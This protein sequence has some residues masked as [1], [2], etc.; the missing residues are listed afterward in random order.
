MVS[1]PSILIANNT[2]VD[3]VSPISRWVNKLHSHC[4]DL[5]GMY[6]HGA[7]GPGLSSSI[8]SIAARP[9]I[10][11][12]TVLGSAHPVWRISRHSRTTSSTTPEVPSSVLTVSMCLIRTTTS[13]PIHSLSTHLRAT[14]TLKT[15]HQQLIM[16]RTVRCK[17]FWP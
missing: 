5:Q 16:A 2:I 10:Q 6:S 13:S 8:T 15:R 17:P 3:N 7:D 11:R 4:A 12:S 14:I 1:N 9:L